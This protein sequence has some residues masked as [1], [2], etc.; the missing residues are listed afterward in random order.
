MD[1]LDE[2]VTQQLSE[3]L[4]TPER[5]SVLLSEIKKRNSGER[6]GAH[7]TMIDLIKERRD[8]DGRL[9][10]LYEAV[11]SGLITDES[12]LR[13]RFA[14]H[15]RRKDEI[16]RQ[17]AMTQRE[18]DMPRNA[19]SQ[20]NLDQFATAMQ[21][22]L[23]HGDRKLQ[24]AYLR[25]FV[26]RIEVHDEEIRIY[27]SKRALESGIAA[28]SYSRGKEV[29]TFVPEWRPQGDSNPRCRRERAVS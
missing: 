3:R 28:N 5:L 7:Q 12:S 1:A 14:H 24:Q 27:G 20:R 2:L 29:P 4:F 16:T 18:L 15:E 19:L 23:K 21:E 26:Q 9:E 6:S 22:T 11:E 17:I 13:D 8:I 10:R 25:L